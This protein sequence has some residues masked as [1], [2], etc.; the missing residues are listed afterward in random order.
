[1]VRLISNK[2]WCYI[3]EQCAKKVVSNSPGLVDFNIG[4]I[5]KC[6][7]LGEIQIIEGL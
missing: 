7:F 2:M 4:L 5:C 3:G 1:M 6:C